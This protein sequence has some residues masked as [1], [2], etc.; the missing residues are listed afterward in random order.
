MNKKLLPSAAADALVQ[1][2]DLTM[3]FGSKL[4]H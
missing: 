2:T 1:V 4:I 3:R